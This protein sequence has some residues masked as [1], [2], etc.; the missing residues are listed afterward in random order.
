MWIMRSS[1]LT[2]VSHLSLRSLEQGLHHSRLIFPYLSHCSDVSQ[3]G[4]L[5]GHSKYI[6]RNRHRGCLG[7]ERKVHA[8]EENYNGYS[9]MSQCR[10]ADGSIQGHIAH[11]QRITLYCRQFSLTKKL[12]TVN[13]RNTSTYIDKSLTECLSFPCRKW[14][15]DAS[16]LS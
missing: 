10:P 11:V 5:S 3:I 9:G 2:A 1:K 4:R 7:Q 14:C 6:E 12:G 13:L 15:A 8:E 16:F